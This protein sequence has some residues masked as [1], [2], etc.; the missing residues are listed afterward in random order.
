MNLMAEAEQRAQVEHALAQHISSIDSAMR[1][2]HAAIESV[3]DASGEALMPVGAGVF[4]RARVEPGSTVVVS[5][6]SGVAAEKTREDALLHLEARS[7]ELEAAAAEA[8]GQLGQ[9]RQQL[10]RARADL[11]ALASKMQAGRDV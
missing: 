3:R 1:G 5:V 4:V 2:T 10:A 8:S 6:G 9:T 11:E 7:K